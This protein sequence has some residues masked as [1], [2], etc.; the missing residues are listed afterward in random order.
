MNSNPAA[1][2]LAER[3]PP[4]APSSTSVP[5]SR[6]VFDPAEPSSILVVDDQ[7]A[8]IQ[9]VGSVLGKL[10][11]EIIPASDGA[12][13]FKRLALRLPDLILLDLLM[14]EMNG[15]EEIGRAHV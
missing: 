4:V 3:Q 7:P 6:P 2:P 5:A 14:P 10:G 8:N 1:A 11:H 13:A 15:Y 12:T 9:V